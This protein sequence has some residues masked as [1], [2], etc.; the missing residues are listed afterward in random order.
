VILP[1]AREAIASLCRRFVE[2][3]LHPVFDNPDRESPQTQSRRSGHAASGD[4][5]AQAMRRTAQQRS[6]QLA[7]RERSAVVRT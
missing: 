3:D 6:F 4:I 5:E 1:A 7:V 2:N